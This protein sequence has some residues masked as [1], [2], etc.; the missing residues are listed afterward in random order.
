MIISLPAEKRRECMLLQAKG[1]PELYF[2]GTSTGQI[3]IRV[4]GGGGGVC[5]AKG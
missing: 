2:R 4:E 5:D 3:A 1:L